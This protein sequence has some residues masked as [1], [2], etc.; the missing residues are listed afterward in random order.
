MKSFPLVLLALLVTSPALAA[1][2]AR[3][4]RQPGEVTEDDEAEPALVSAVSLATISL[5][6]GNTVEFLE[7][8]P[9]IVF[10]VEEGRF[11]QEPVVPGLDLRPDATPADVFRAL[12]PGRAVPARMQAATLVVAEPEETAE[13]DRLRDVSEPGE[14]LHIAARPASPAIRAVPA[15]P[16]MRAVPAE[17]QPAAPLEPKADPTGKEEQADLPT[18]ESATRAEWFQSQF[19]G[20]GGDISW[21]WL[22]RTGTSTKEAWGIA[23]GAVVY[24]C[25]GTARFK[26]Q[27]K[28]FG[29]WKTYAS[30]DVLPG[31]YRSFSRWGVPRTRRSRV[32]GQCF[33]HAGAGVRL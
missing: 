20:G 13:D 3:A 30:Y 4:I 17:A 2:E 9:G 8:E 11:P 6:N 5:G 12:A 25:G 21:C 24:S 19:C 10:L 23:I 16:A 27:Y 7:P 32:E 29:K 1:Q 14:S 26:L 31:Y 22:D 28:R 15:Q 33:H 18:P